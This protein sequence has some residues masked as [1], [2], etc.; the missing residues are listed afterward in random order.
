MNLRLCAIAATAYGLCAMKRSPKSI[1]PRSV[2]T[3]GQGVN[4]ANSV[5][6]LN[7]YSMLANYNK[8]MIGSNLK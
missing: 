7:S 1:K 6:N 5:D 3:F 4:V 2:E 8:A